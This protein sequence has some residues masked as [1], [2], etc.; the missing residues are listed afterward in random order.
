MF[1]IWLLN[2]QTYCLITSNIPYSPNFNFQV[3]M[4]DIP[5][6]PENIPGFR[7]IPQPPNSNVLY[8]E[9]EL[10]SSNNLDPEKRNL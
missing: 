8:Q 4:G 2:Q 9:D 5:P 7:P 10:I 6:N 3:I 1:I